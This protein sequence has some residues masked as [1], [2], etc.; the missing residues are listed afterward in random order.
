ML[1][2]S[3]EGVCEDQ[4]SRR[5]KVGLRLGIAIAVIFFLPSFKHL[6]WP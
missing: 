5:H 1:L 4:R 3:S 6:I 2:L